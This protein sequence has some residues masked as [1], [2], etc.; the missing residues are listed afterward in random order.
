MSITG[1]ADKSANNGDV[2]P[3]ITYSDTN[4]NKDAVTITLSGINNGKDLKYTGSFADIANG[5]TYTYANFEKIQSVDDIYTLTAKLTDMA[6]NE[7]EAT[8]TFSANRFGSVY[9]LTGL[10][11]ILTKY[12]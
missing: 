8:I 7:T 3:I 5:Q 9:N 2:A 12:L 1:V 10:E 4:F 6:G 11:N